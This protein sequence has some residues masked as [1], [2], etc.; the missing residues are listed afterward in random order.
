MLRFSSGFELN[1]LISVLEEQ[2]KRNFYSK[3]SAAEFS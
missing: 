2:E 3:K 1:A